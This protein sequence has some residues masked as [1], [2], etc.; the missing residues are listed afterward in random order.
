[1][2]ETVKNASL[3]GQTLYPSTKTKSHFRIASPTAE[4]H[5][6][7]QHAHDGL[8]GP[9]SPERYDDPASVSLAR[10]ILTN[11][12]PRGSGG[13]TSRNRTTAATR[14]LKANITM[15]KRPMIMHRWADLTVSGGS[16]VRAVR[17]RGTGTSPVRMRPVVWR[18]RP[19]A[20][21][22]GP[23]NTKPDRHDASPVHSDGTPF[24]RDDSFQAKV[25]TRTI[26]NV[27]RTTS[28]YTRV[29]GLKTHGVDALYS[30]REP[31][32][33]KDSTDCTLNATKMDPKVYF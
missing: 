15:A 3:L 23:D 20:R 5:G 13:P 31:N 22:A 2:G 18:S 17:G 28:S 9:I 4:R 32:T 11:A 27:Y 12:N 21:R 7:M 29:N 1:M 19:R 10:D 16:G 14:M 8:S 6:L 33:V 24:C 26:Q 25:R 30:V